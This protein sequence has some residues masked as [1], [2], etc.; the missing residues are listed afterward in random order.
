MPE[1]NTSTDVKRGLLILN[2][3]TPD[4]PKPSA[5]ERYLKQFLMDKWVIDIAWPLRWFFV[6]VL[7]VPKRKFASAEA[8]EKIWTERGSPLLFHLKDLAAKVAKLR[9]DLKVATAMRYGSHST[10][11]GLSLLSDCDEILIFH[12][13][14]QYAESSTRSSREECDRAAKHLGLKAQLTFVKD[15]FEHPEFIESFADVIRLSLERDKPDHAHEFS[16]SPRETRQA[17]RSY[18]PTLSCDDIVL[19]YADTC[20]PRL[21]PRAELCDRTGA[22]TQTQA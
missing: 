2:L 8:Y 9:P 6:N 17:H 16:R 4:E 22:C 11:K 12:L 19:R 13:Y 21:L 5:V 14:P 3:G 10:E 1:M 15:Y 7:I 18:R 20:E